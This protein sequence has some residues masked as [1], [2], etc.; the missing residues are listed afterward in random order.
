MILTFIVDPCATHYL[1]A[2]KMDNKPASLADVDIH[3][4]VVER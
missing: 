2:L 4:E 1:V 3:F